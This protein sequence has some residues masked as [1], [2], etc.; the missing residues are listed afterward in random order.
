M[1]ARRITEISRY[2]RKSVARGHFDTCA[3]TIGGDSDENV[4]AYVTAVTEGWACGGDTQ[5]V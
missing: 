4:G 2:P 1:I 3:V 5:E